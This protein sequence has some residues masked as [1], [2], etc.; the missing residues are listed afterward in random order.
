[1]RPAWQQR[2]VR[3]SCRCRR[4]SGRPPGFSTRAKRS[5]L[6]GST[7]RRF[8]CSSSARGRDRAGRS[9]RAKPPAASRA[10]AS[11]RRHR[12]GD[13]RA[14]CRS[15]AAHQLGH[16]VDERLDADE[17]GCR[18]RPPR[19]AA[20]ARRRRSRSRADLARPAPRTGCADRPG[21]AA[22]RSSRIARQHARPARR[23]AAGAWS[24][25]A[26]GRKTLRSTRLRRS[27]V[28][29]S[30]RDR[31]QAATASLSALT[32]SVFSQEKEPSRPGLRPKWP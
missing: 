29:G 23:P 26:G 21:G 5:R 20:D 31:R 13:W 3:H 7:K 2:P 22:A 12:P 1:M 17:A 8:Q 16:A 25:R 27:A 4:R 10:G 28:I 9:R 18:A 24:C 15:T 11:R 30:C 32:R 19:G 6:A 14:A